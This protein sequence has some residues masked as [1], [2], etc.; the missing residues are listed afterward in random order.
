MPNDESSGGHS[1]R[2][3]V[4]VSA[5]AFVGVGAILAAWP[6]IDQMN[7][8]PGTPRPETVTVDLDPIRPGQTLSVRWKGWPIVILNRTAAQIAMS[9]SVAIDALPDRLARNANLPADAPAFDANR[10]DRSNANWLVVIAVCTHMGC[11]LNARSESGGQG[12]DEAWVCPCHASR[13]DFAGRVRSG[14][15]RTNLPV[16]PYQL[17]DRNRVIIG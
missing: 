3:F 5:G 13:F 16:P 17:I 7:P 12:P 2:D 14:P 10:A 9:R 4:T 15:A 1:R 8:N 11:R 6:L